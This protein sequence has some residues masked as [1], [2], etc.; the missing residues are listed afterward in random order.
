L[1][2]VTQPPPQYLPVVGCHFA[3]VK[4]RSDAEQ[5][6][7]AFAFKN[8]SCQVC[9]AQQNAQTSPLSWLPKAF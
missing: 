3:I 6:F 8:L 9:T 1:G 5:S 7:S 4:S 2:Q